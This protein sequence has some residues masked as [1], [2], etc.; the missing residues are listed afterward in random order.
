M[1][2]EMSQLTGLVFDPRFLAHDTGVE[3]TVVLRDTTFELSPQPHPSSLVITRRIKEFLDGAGL[4]AQM[5]PIAARPA[6]EEELLMYHTREYLEGIR[7]YAA[8][9]PAS[10][11]WGYA[12]EET[13]LSPGSFV[14]ALY[15]A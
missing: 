1:E 8:G 11:S 2:H 6:S 13:V 4:T 14:A 7:A 12:D 9:G 3:A 10:G 15:A 5:V